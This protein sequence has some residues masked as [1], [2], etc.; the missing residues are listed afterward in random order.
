MYV[1]L[2]FLGRRDIKS[3][4]KIK[5]DKNKNKVDDLLY[6]D[7]GHCLSQHVVCHNGHAD[8][9]YKFSTV[10]GLVVVILFIRWGHANQ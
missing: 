4:K 9:H 7:V 10:K 2:S 6:H 8:F 3:E 1:G 5:N